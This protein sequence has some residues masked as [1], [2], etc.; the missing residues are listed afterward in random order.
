M[1]FNTRFI[2][3]T[4]LLGIMQAHSYQCLAQ[5]DDAI[6]HVTILDELEAELEKPHGNLENRAYWYRKG[7]KSRIETIRQVIEKLK[8][9]E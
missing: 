4:I 2:R 6:L 5:T 3:L 7:L 1:K 8:N 9:K